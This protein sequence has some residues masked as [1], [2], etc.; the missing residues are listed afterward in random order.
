MPEA[1]PSER[2]PI[3]PDPDSSLTRPRRPSQPQPRL[4]PLKFAVLLLLALLLVAIWLGWQERERLNAQLQQVSAEMSNVHA[5]F[6]AEEGRGDRLENIESRLSS[7]EE[8]AESIVARMAGLEVEVQ[9]VSEGDASR[10]EALDERVDDVS[11]RLGRLA[12]EAED[13]DALLVAVRASLDSLERAGEEGRN[14]LAARVE[15]LAEASERHGQRL[16]ELR[17]Q[18]EELAESQQ[19]VRAS[20]DERF[21]STDQQVRQLVEQEL[22]ALEESFATREAALQERLDELSGELEAVAERGDAAQDIETLRG[23]LTSMEAELRELRQ[24][25]LSL[26][27]GLE[28]L[29]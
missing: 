29:R 7:T 18:Q 5:R 27:A 3:V 17:S 12:E 6:D 1:R 13:R 19:G 2:R 11:A 10:F 20:F 16:D 25:Q 28:A 24:E 9:Q 14:A 22:A 23:R 21:D 8:H 26:S 4:W 15:A